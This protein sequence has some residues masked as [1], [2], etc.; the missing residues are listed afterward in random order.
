MNLSN[1]KFAQANELIKAT[2]K[3]NSREIK[4]FFYAC[5]IRDQ[6]E[7]VINVP[8]VELCKKLEVSKG[9]KQKELFE[10]A[11]ENLM[12]KDLIKLE[13]EENRTGKRIIGHVFSS[14]RWNTS[15]VD[16]IF[17]RDFIPLLDNL[18]SDYTWMYFEQ[19]AKLDR[20]YSPRIYEFLKMTLKNNS[21]LNFRWYLDTR[22][23]KQIG[24][25][26]FLGIEHLKAYKRFNNLRSRILEPCFREINEKSSDVS[27]GWDV[28]YR[29]RSAIAIDLRI[30]SSKELPL[31]DPM[32]PKHADCYDVDIPEG[33]M[34]IN[35]IILER[36]R[37]GQIYG[38]NQK[39]GSVRIQQINKNLYN[40]LEE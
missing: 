23:D 31:K 10:K 32:H 11:W 30:Y 5:T 28:Y 16:I 22:S 14:I 20:E 29:G 38:R 36:P 4:T 2:R 6:G 19:L 15:N 7:Q 35:D 1:E 25:K 37:S 24:L 3:M 39:P 40:W 18:K 26:E 8:Y 17:N 12:S 34:S 9:G 27:V 13:P 33:Q 21:E